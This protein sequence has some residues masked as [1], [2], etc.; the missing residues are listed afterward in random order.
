MGFSY[1]DW[2]IITIAG[3]LSSLLF[4]PLWGKFTD[5]F[6]SVKTIS[7]TGFIIL[8]LIALSR[9]KDDRQLKKEEKSIPNL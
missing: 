6:G 5:R 3:S 7:I 1:L 4:M 9:V 8:G 2:T